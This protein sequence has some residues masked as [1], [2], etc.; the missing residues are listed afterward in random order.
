MDRDATQLLAHCLALA[1]VDSDFDIQTQL[2]QIR[3]D[4][5]RRPD[6]ARG[7]VECG[8]KTISCRIDLAPTRTTEVRANEGVMSL[9]QVAP[10]AVAKLDG[11]SRRVGDVRE[12]DRRENAIGFWSMTRAGEKLLDLTD[13]AVDITG[14]RRMIVARQFDVL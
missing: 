1:R 8:K 11:L 12:Q 10:L 13:E 14:P 5:R 2:L 9:E 3:R 4:G 7:T 6:R